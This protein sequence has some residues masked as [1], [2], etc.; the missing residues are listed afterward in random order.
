MQQLEVKLSE[1]H[2][3][4]AQEE[5]SEKVLLLDKAKKAL[6]TKDSVL[7][8]KK[9]ELDKII[10]ATEKEERHFSKLSSEAREKIEPRL[11]HSRSHPT[12][13]AMDWP[14]PVV[15][16]ACGVPF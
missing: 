9:E 12:N 3:K 7:K 8:N 15:R 16:E 11:L 10:A 1:K 14:V 2:I 5:V 6:A 13:T 4:D